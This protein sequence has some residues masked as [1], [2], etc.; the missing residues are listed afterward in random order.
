M[1]MKNIKNLLNDL[2]DEAEKSSRAAGFSTFVWGSG[3]P[4]S[5]IV[6]IGEAPGAE[7][8]AHSTPFVGRAGKFLRDELRALGINP[9]EIWITN[10]VKH[11]PTKGDER[12]LSNRPPKLEEIDFWS[13]FLQRELQIIN[14]KRILCLGSVAAQALVE[15][16]KSLGD[17]HGKML[18]NETGFHIMISYHPSY[19][20]RTLR[21]F[22]QDVSDAFRCDLKAFFYN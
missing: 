22:K 3:D 21:M 14:P 1:M 11:R 15:C 19:V 7:E 2:R 4:E 6:I 10:V 8:V 12:R 18:V 13:P 20:L 16:K 17:I 9:D 5:G